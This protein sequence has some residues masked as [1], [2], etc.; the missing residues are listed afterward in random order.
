M[1]EPMRAAVHDTMLGFRAART[2][3]LAAEQ[4]AKRDGMTVSELL[5]HALRQQL[6]RP[7]T[8]AR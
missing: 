3:V 6:H 8:E 1:S 7:K 5:R 4:Q 2:L